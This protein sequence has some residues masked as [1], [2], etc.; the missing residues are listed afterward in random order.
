M[1]TLS[2]FREIFLF[3]CNTGVKTL[4]TFSF[5]FNG[6]F[7]LRYIKRITRIPIISKIELLVTLVN[8]FQSLTNVTMNY[9]LSVAGSCICYCHNIPINETE[10]VRKLHFHDPFMKYNECSSFL[11]YFS[12]VLPLFR[13]QLVIFKSNPWTGLWIRPETDQFTIN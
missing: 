2:F 4:L 11:T 7:S 10:W 12:P 6:T 9:I 8:D 1:K 3:S 5:C 13:N